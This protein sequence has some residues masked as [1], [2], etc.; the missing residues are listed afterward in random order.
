[1][2]PIEL[3]AVVLL[4]ALLLVGWRLWSAVR[5][6]GLDHWVPAAILSRRRPTPLDDRDGPL[7]VFIAVCDHFEPEWGAADPVTARQRVRQWCDE[8]PRLFDRFRD[9]EDRP[10]Q[11]TFFFPQDQ[12]RPEYLDL[13]AEL[14]LQGY[15]D[16]DIHL[17]HH[18]DTPAGLRKKLAG[19][20]DAL[21]YR[22]GLLRR[23]PETGEIAYGFI[24]GDWALCNSRRDGRWCGVDH[25]IPILRETGCYADFTLPSAPSDTQTRTINSIYYVVDRP[26][27]RKSHDVGVPATVGR[28]PPAHGLLMIQGPLVFD[29]TR[30]KWGVVPRIE[31]GDLLHSHPPSVRRLP[32]WLNAGVTVAGQP[33]WRFIKL[34]THGCK[35]ANQ[36][37]WLGETVQRFHVDLAEYHRRHPNFRYHYVSAWEM[38]QLVHRAERGI[39]SEHSSVAEV[40]RLQSQDLATYATTNFVK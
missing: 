17:H 6:R 37:M 14:V 27:R 21:F 2:Q 22:H 24:H 20:R 10:P 19:F 3:L 33:N 36:Q 38:A 28:T 29:F 11:H 25:E 32:A 5:A 34:H 40:A 39:I 30:K 12:Y 31:N 7:D 26:G 23:D 16:V 8:Y 13:L 35:P 9:I 15:G 4:L 18:H 1:M